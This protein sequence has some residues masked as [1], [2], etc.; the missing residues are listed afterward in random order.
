MTFMT[1]LSSAAQAVKL[2]GDEIRDLLTG[3]T[4]IGRW[5]GA[6]YRQHFGV[7]GSQ[8]ILRKVHAQLEGYGGSMTTLRS[9]RASGQ[10]MQTGKVGL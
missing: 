1:A 2:S 5:E 6:K 4:A 3:N 8:F 9:I 10:E 7:D